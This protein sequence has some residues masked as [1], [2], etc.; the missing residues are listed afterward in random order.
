MNYRHAFHAGNFA[1][2]LKH[3]ALLR[4]MTLLQAGPEPLTVIDTHAGAGRY[5]L[6]AHHLA[7][8]EA[9]A[10]ARLLTGE[11]PEVFASLIAATERRGAEVLY[12]GSPLLAAR[13]LRGQDH[14]IAFELR[15]EEQA[16]LAETLKPFA[17]TARAVLGD[18]YAELPNAIPRA[19]R[20]LVL[21]D[22]PY[23]RSDDYDRASE[24][25]AAALGASPSAGVLIWTPLK[26]LETFDRFLRELED[27]V[28]APGFAL[29]LR[30][31]PPL[32]P[33]RLNGCGV[34]AL[35][36]PAG[37]DAD[38]Q[39]AGDWIAAELGEPGGRAILRRLNPAN[40]PEKRG[41]E[42]PRSRSECAAQ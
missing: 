22:P 35:N 18:G 11:P 34:V 40:A 7:R 32:D 42:T 21:I 2:L 23:E 8:G 39:A 19:G 6:T 30:L 17:D 31:R 14:L 28:A 15:P 24:A 27:R 5:R 41:A 10:V 16:V 38:V 9:A 29:E 25:A 3:A 20:A 13:K 12:P 26:D 37:L 1:D 33:L 4:T 36:P